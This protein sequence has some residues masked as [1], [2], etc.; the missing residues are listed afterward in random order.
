MTGLME[1]E[2]KKEGV[3][4]GSCYGVELIVNKFKDM[5]VW[6][7][8][9]RVCKQCVEGKSRPSES[10]IGLVSHSLNYTVQAPMTFY[11]CLMLSLMLLVSLVCLICRS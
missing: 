2:R 5:C 6:K 4:C 11:L 1:E 10:D 7:K 9:E 8:S 3:V